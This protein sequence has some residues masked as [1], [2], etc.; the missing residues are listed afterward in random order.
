MICKG[1]TQAAQ[2][3]EAVDFAEAPV[4]VVATARDMHAGAMEFQQGL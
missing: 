2:M 4:D 3:L 1:I